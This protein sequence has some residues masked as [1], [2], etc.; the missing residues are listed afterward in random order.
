MMK[1]TR[2]IAIGLLLL[3]SG[4]KNETQTIKEPWIDKPLSQ[5]PNFA[6]TNEISFKDTTYKV[7]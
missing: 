7:Y 6:L 2:L 1:G 5:W 4:C 3:V